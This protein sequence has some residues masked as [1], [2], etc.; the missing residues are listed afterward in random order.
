[1]T[2]EYRY[3]R[4]E[5]VRNANRRYYTRNAEMLREKTRAYDASHPDAKIERNKRFAEL[6]PTYWR[7][8]QRKR[9]MRLAWAKFTKQ[10]AESRRRVAA[11]TPPTTPG[12]AGEV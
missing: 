12:G 6:N 10:C 1:M 11:L 9:R 4:R 8:F 2:S 7:D 3:N 5:Q